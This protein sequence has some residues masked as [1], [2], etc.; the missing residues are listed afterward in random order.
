MSITKNNVIF[1]TK[2]SAKTESSTDIFARELHQH[3]QYYHLLLAG[4]TA[5]TYLS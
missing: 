2:K 5:K 4:S 1:D 3:V